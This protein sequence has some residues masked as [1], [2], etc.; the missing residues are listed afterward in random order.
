MHLPLLELLRR[1][2]RRLQLGRFQLLMLLQL[3][4]RQMLRLV[5]HVVLELLDA[6]GQ[7]LLPAH[8]RCGFQERRPCRS[9]P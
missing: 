6:H 1:P 8:V 9:K 7:Q 2:V 5:E 4:L 3:N